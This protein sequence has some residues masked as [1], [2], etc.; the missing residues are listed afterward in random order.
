M[1]MPYLNSK[2]EI[3]EALVKEK[4]I[5]FI[6]VSNVLGFLALV[7]YAF[8]KSTIFQQRK[9]LKQMEIFNCLQEGIMVVGEKNNARKIIF[10]N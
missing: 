8:Q 10:R 7:V 6:S 1:I 3:D 4:A 5:L 2:S 9:V